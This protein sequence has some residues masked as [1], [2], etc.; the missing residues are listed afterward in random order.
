M[1]LGTGIEHQKRAGTRPWRKF[2]RRTG[3]DSL[4]EKV[5]PA[6]SGHMGSNPIGRT[7]L[8]TAFAGSRSP[9]QNSDAMRGANEF[10]IWGS[11]RPVLFE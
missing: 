4:S 8:L 1:H 10:P 2:G 9:K 6:S 5:T 7:N 11:E 3:L